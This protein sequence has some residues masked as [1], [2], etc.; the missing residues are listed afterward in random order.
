MSDGAGTHDEVGLT[1]GVTRYLES[2]AGEVVTGTAAG[3]ELDAAAR[4]GKRQ[5][6]QRVG[7]SP[8]NQLVKRTRDDVHATLVQLVDNL[9]QRLVVVPL[10]VRNALDFRFQFHSNAP[11]RQ[12]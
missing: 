4:R 9:L 2:K 5:R 6:P 3:H 12:A 1:G 8:V 11:F 7:A 10:V